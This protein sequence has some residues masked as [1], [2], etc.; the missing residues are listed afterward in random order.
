MRDLD[1]IRSFLSSAGPA[2]LFD[3]PWMPLYVG[4]CYLFHPLIGI[5]AASGALILIVLTIAGRVC[6]A[7][8]A[9]AAVGFAAARHTLLEASRRNAEVVQALGMGGAMSAR[10]GAANEQYLRSQRRCV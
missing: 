8:P 6:D 4:I 9:K 7:N 1:Q 3:L 10:F 2:A 5:A